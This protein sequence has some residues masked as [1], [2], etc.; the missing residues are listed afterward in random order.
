M[1]LNGGESLSGDNAAA[2]LLVSSYVYCIVT[3]RSSFILDQT[4]M[5]STCRC[6]NLN[7]LGVRLNFEASMD[8]KACNSG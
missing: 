3:H 4:H 8:H 1:E 5:Y 6:R 7:S 2:S